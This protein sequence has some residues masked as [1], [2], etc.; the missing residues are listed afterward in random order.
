MR[1]YLFL[2]MLVIFTASAYAQDRHFGLGVVFGEPTG[3][4]AKYWTRENNALSFGLGWYP[5]T[6]VRRFGYYY[7]TDTRF[8]IHAD[9]LWHDFNAIRSSERFPLYY[10]VG[11]EVESGGIPDPGVGV[12][13]VFGI[14]WMPHNASLDVFLEVAPTLF[15]SPP[16]G[17]GIGLGLGS[18]YFF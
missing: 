4:S 3:I 9:Y 7:Y 12:R 10:G 2:S 1:K 18:R 13:G 11:A 15:L 17:F 6:V 5:Q 16:A 8:H 14:A